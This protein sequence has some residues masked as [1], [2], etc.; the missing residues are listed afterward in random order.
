M[1]FKHYHQ[2]DA[3]DCGPTCLK[4]IAK[5]YGRDFDIQ[6]LRKQSFISRR[7]VSLLGIS[8]AAEH[9]GFRTMAIKIPFLSDGLRAGL[10]EAPFPCIVHWRQNHFIVIYKMTK[11]H[12]WIADPAEGKFKLA[13]TTFEQHWLSDEQKGVALL[14][15]PTPKFYRHEGENIS[16]AGFAFLFQYLKR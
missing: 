5:Y 4:M 10:Q 11:K 16:K 7:G 1:R 2:L 13:R 12:V 15:N 8:D 9:I 6:Y 3:M 14:L